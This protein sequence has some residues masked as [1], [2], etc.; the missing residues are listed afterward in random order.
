LGAREPASDRID[1][2]L[3]CPSSNDVAAF[4][5]GG[6]PPSAE[7]ALHAHLA[8]CAACRELVSTVARAG[9]TA[10]LAL[11]SSAAATLRAGE[12]GSASSDGSAGDEPLHP[13]DAIGRYLV[14]G[15]VGAGS[16]GVVYAAL[17][18]ELDRAVAIKILR[19]DADAARRAELEDRMIREA[20]AM[21]QLAHPNVVA[22]FE[23]GRFR[24]QVFL[25]ME[26]VDGWTLARWLALAPRSRRDILGVFEAAG[27][28]LAAAHAA[29]LVHRDFKP[30]NVL[31]GRD[32]RVRV[33]DFGLVHD[34]SAPR[35]GELVGTPY[36]I[37]PEQFRGEPADPRSDQFA[38]CVA[39]YRALYRA[40]PFAGDTVAELA[41]AVTSG[42]VRPPPARARVPRWLARVIARGLSAAP[43]DRHASMDALRRALERDPYR[44]LRRAGAV[45][46]IAAAT[47]AAT[48]VLRGPGDP[49]PSCAGAAGR[50][51]ALWG[52]E[53]RQQVAAAFVRSGKPFAATALAEVTRVLDGYHASLVDMRIDLCETVRDAPAPGD[54]ASELAGLRGAC[55]DRELGELRAQIAALTTADADAVARAPRAVHDLPDPRSCAD[56]RALLGPARMPADLV[57][58]AQITAMHDALADAEAVQRLGRYAQA[59]R[60]ARALL[61]PVRALHYRPLE[62]ETAL[63]IGLSA[64]ESGKYGEAEPSL[65]QAVF[66]AEAGRNDEV[67]I[68]ALIYLMYIEGLV[69]VHPAQ[70]M[71]D[72]APRIRAALERLGGSDELE[73]RLHAALSFL[74][75]AANR[76][77]DSDRESRLALELLER[78]FGRDDLRL[79]SALQTRIWSALYHDDGRTALELAQRMLAIT[80]RVYGE[81]HSDVA[82]AYQFVAMAVYRTPR[83][84][85]ARPAFERALAI[86]ERTRGPDHPV[87]A[88]ALGEF[89]EYDKAMGRYSDA[90]ALQRRALAISE[91]VYGPH[92]RNYGLTRLWM[93]QIFSEQGR[94][95]EALAALREAQASFGPTMGEDS[96]EMSEQRMTTGDVLAHLG[97]YAEAR[98]EVEASLATLDRL[99]KPGHPWSARRLRI[100]GQIDLG[101]GQPRAAL[102]S[103][104][105]ARALLDPNDPS[106]GI[107]RAQVDF[108]TAQALT[109]VHQD[110]ARAHALAGSARD[111]LADC[112]ECTATRQ[113]IEAWLAG[114]PGPHTP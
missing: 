51:A 98:T 23:I 90:L 63:V 86:H 62:A 67:A 71:E 64:Y 79:T 96:V 101:V 38:F 9:S 100:L 30:A 103:F 17:D 13:G 14:Q 112:A 39:L 65:K 28:G 42:R 3:G 91:R 106:L 68:R 5:D 73:G 33:G 76:Y 81:D 16:A 31:V 6:L 18:R 27:R 20:R 32:G 46:A 69:Q 92:S 8:A 24:D 97:R 109:A 34:G 114:H 93:G 7:R 99:F 60:Q 77:D 47:V 57:A 59:N 66:A 44:R 53:S 2:E 40:H 10:G 113:P 1:A 82:T 111:A 89:A 19:P 58:R 74:A 70:A 48:L 72:H 29:G 55:L 88:D 105:R 43:A 45:A 12:P 36:F 15:R 84:G 35:P 37:A 104:E 78:R 108:G 107:V 110:P 85:E 26:L 11:D 4:V 87:F 83:A 56:A 61:E 94:T 49:R 95:A 22:V 21:A 41:D 25:A 50:A 52:P 102:A 54:A 80:T 75:M